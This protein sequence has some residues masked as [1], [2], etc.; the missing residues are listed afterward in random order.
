MSGQLPTDEWVKAAESMVTLQH[1]L[2]NL[3]SSRKDEPADDLLTSL[4][5]AATDANGKL[6]LPKAV[7]SA[8][9]F[10]FAGHKTTT[11]LIGNALRLLLLHPEHLAA[12]VRDPS[13]AAAV[14]EETIRFDCP[15]PGTA[16]VA[17][18]DVTIGDVTI[19]K[20]ARVLVLLGSANR[21]ESVFAEPAKF[22]V[23]RPDASDHIGFG[24][25]VHFCLGAPLARLQGRVALTVLTQRLRGLRFANDQA[26][27][28][29]QVTMH[30]GPVSLEV[31]WDVG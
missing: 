2:A 11:D 12:L 28:F 27:R 26:V 25:G 29:R 21:D 6:D 7:T 14:I 4:I 19:P 20:D 17:K 24:R 18:V 30:R 10:V 9:T 1:H 8:T 13:L 22:D 16:R 3:I 5:Q 23:G 15:V 31:A